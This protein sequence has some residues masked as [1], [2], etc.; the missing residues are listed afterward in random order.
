[1]KVI[2]LKD[3]KAQGKA[4]DIIEASEGYAR[5]FLLSKGFAVEATAKN[6]N[7]IKLKKQNDAKVAAQE[8]ADAKEGKD[9][10][11]SASKQK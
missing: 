4:G 10:S 7:D 6:L 3:V 5:N 2:L 9:L 1:M 11:F 8:L